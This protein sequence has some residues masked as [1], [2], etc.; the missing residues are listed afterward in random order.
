MKNFTVGPVEPYACIQK[1]YTREIPYFRTEVYSDLVKSNLRTLSGWLDM[2][3]G[4]ELLYFACSGT[5]AME[6]A[7]D[8]CLNEKDRALVINGGTFGARF[9]SLL[10]KHH[11]PYSS[12]NLRWN[13]ALTE[14]HLSEYQDK[15]YTA[16]LVNLHETSSGQFYDI[17]ML[18]RFCA[19]NHMYLIVD[20]I[21]TFMADEY[22]MKKYGVDVTIFSSQ[23]ALGLSPGMSFVALSKR[24]IEK[25]NDNPSSC[26]FDFKDS[27]NNIARGQTPFTP[28]VNIMYELHYMINYIEEQGGLSSWL[29]H[30][31]AKC[32]YFRQKIHGKP[33]YINDAYS[34]SNMLTPVIFSGVDAYDVFKRLSSEFGFYVNP[35]GGELASSMLRISH[36]GNTSMEDID[37]LIAAIDQIVK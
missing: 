8:N 24:M 33:Y 20:A 19:R 26:Y 10:E 14:L 3:A 1:A 36:V 22:S 31:A 27:L 4:S 23:K 2:E 7:V 37:Q 28:A 5:G 29:E 15:G 12:V 13:E 17:E 9:C 6:A 32:R 11:V 18:S 34:L 30:I 16:L 35:C 21:S 25:L